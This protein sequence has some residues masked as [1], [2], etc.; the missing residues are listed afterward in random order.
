MAFADTNS[1]DT[2]DTGAKGG[3]APGT[4]ESYKAEYYAL[5]AVYKKVNAKHEDYARLAA[6]L[7]SIKT[8]IETLFGVTFSENPDENEGGLGGLVGAAAAA[9][10][11]LLQTDKNAPDYPVTTR[12]IHDVYTAAYNKLYITNVGGITITGY[13]I[14]AQKGLVAFWESIKTL[15]NAPVISLI[16][17]GGLDS[18]E[19]AILDAEELHEV[20]EKYGDCINDDSSHRNGKKIFGISLPSPHSLGVGCIF[21]ERPILVPTD[22]AKLLN[23]TGVTGFAKDYVS[24]KDEY[25]KAYE[26]I[27]IRKAQDAKAKKVSKLTTLAVNDDEKIVADGV[28]AAAEASAVSYKGL[29]SVAKSE[30]TS[31]VGVLKGS[32]DVA[33]SVTFVDTFPDPPKKEEPE[34]PNPIIENPNLTTPIVDDPATED[35]VVQEPITETP[36]LTTPEDRPKETKQPRIFIENDTG[37]PDSAARV[38]PLPAV[39]FDPGEIITEAPVKGILSPETPQNAFVEEQRYSELWY[40]GLLADIAAFAVVCV[41]VLWRRRQRLNAGEEFF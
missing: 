2:P 36:A 15:W 39:G 8:R 7:T 25:K 37:A 24:A 5:E 16:T 1:D 4:W 29:I 31:E 20:I 40:W 9:D 19:Q 14:G 11:E 17:K 22:R 6:K 30:L 13:S 28:I 3:F 27:L 26:N 34:N 35:I 38:A 41:I 32:L 10:F 23:A 12:D 33:V 18:P 21:N